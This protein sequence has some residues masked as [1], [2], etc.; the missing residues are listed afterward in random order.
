MKEYMEV[1]PWNVLYETGILEIDTEHEIIVSILNKLARH[2]HYKS[3][4]SDIDAI[5]N[6]LMDYIDYHFVKE[7]IL[8]K[9][10][11]GHDDYY[12]EHHG[13]HKSFMKRIRTMNDCILPLDKVIRSLTERVAFHIIES[14]RV[15]VHMVKN[16]KN[17]MSL[18]DAKISANNMPEN[19]DL[20]KS[21]LEH[22]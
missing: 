19:L 1:L 12:I 20:F 10:Y 6:K 15:L 16:M 11:I 4:K 5:Y 2:I 22:L 8:W 9:Q 7:D 13:S 18:E 14:D 21:I 17:G 3:S